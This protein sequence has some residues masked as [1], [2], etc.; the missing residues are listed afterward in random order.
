MI[1]K[2]SWLRKDDFKEKSQCFWKVNLNSIFRPYMQWLNGKIRSRRSN[3][4]WIGVFQEYEPGMP[5]T[6]KIICEITKNCKELTKKVSKIFMIEN[7]IFKSRQL[8]SSKGCQFSLLLAIN[9]IPVSHCLTQIFSFISITYPYPLTLRRKPSV[10][11]EIWWWLGLFLSCCST[12]AW[13]LIVAV[14]CPLPCSLRRMRLWSFFAYLYHLCV[15]SAFR[16]VFLLM[17]ICLFFLYD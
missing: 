5:F 9:D 17:I 4:S 1:F 7:T 15:V 10:G 12:A 16:P 3:F 14:L 2:F 6:F 8:Y 11:T 13:N